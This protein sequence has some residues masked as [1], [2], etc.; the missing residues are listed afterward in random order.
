M[1]QKIRMQNFESH[2]DTEI[3]FTEGMN[4]I[5]GQS[6]SGK[7]SI[8]RALRMVV[9]NEWNKDMVRN[10]YEYCR[11]RV[12]TDRGWVEAERGEKVNRWRCQENEGELQEYKKVGTSVPEL[13]TKILGMGQR[14][15]G[16][17]IKELPNFQSQLEKH[18]MLSE[19]GEKKSTSGLVAVMMDNAIGLGGMEELI[20]D[21]S[22]DMQRDRKWISSTQSDIEGI[23]KGMV[24][25]TLFESY[26]NLVESIG[27]SME[28]V[29]STESTLNTAETMLERHDGLRRSLDKADGSLSLYPD[30]G[31]V[32][33]IL[34]EAGKLNAGIS[35]LESTAALEAEVE[36]AS[37]PLAVDADGLLEKCSACKAMSD[38]ISRCSDG[39]ALSR[40][41]A[42]ASLAASVDTDSMKGLLDR[43]AGLS[44]RIRDAEAA[45]SM[46]R[47]T[48]KDRADAVKSE[49]ALSEELEKAAS[50]LERLK[51]ELGICPLCGGK[52]Q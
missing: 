20:K 52:L 12:T 15:R 40:R 42:E 49:K 11:V 48:W 3:E 17:G 30:F 43:I 34:D 7:S 27:K 22:T 21:F 24:D 8:L 51:R 33:G 4:L 18:Y 35:L 44:S 1:I 25:E 38:R 13:A 46:A 23:R 26:G 19:I 45:L 50:G 6:N 41:L 32:D 31:E 9:D 47:K 14:E 37:R 2:E 29:E 36:R 16:A 28:S 39:L 10:G 5:V